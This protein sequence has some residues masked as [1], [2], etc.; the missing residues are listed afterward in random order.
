MYKRRPLWLL[1][2]IVAFQILSALTT[3]LPTGPEYT[4]IADEET[5]TTDFLVDASQFA[6]LLSTHLLFDHVENAFHLLSKQISS[7]FRESIQVNVRL[8]SPVQYEDTTYSSVDVQILK[9]QLNGAVG[10]K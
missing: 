1:V 5:A 3:A 4:P 7:R 8:Q 2:T 10:C 9:G 6:H